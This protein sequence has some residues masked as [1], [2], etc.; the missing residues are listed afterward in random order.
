MTW[1]IW[2]HHLTQYKAM[3]IVHDTIQA[4]NDQ[5]NYELQYANFD[6]NNLNHEYNWTLDDIVC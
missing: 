4:H 6:H 3:I 1:L 5:F 2:T